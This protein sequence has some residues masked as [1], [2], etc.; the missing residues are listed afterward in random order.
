M[1]TEI[2]TK[3]ELTEQSKSEWIKPELEVCELNQTQAA[4]GSG[5][6]TGGQTT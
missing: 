4:G 3:A 6:D 2:D 1:K 5:G